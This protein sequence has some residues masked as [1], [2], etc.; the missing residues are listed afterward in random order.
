[1]RCCARCV[2]A[3][4]SRWKFDTANETI[5]ATEH[6]R[7]RQQPIE[8]DHRRKRRDEGCQSDDELRD[9]YAHRI[10]HDLQVGRKSRDQLAGTPFVEL[11]ERQ[12]QQAIEEP[13]AEPRDE[14][15]T[16]PRGQVGLAVDADV[17]QDERDRRQAQS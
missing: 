13:H 2:L 15:L 11:A 17:S 10:D 4:I 5:G 9:R 7:E 16:A 6:E 8:I 3:E 14:M 1:M 12:A